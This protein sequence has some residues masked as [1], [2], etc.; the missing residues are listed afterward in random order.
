MKKAIFVVVWLMVSTL[1]FGQDGMSLDELFK[2]NYETPLTIDIDELNSDEEG[3]FAPNEK[4]GKEKK[5]NPK[6]FYGIKTKRGFAKQGIGNRMTVELFF[7]L[8]DKDYEG[9]T[10]YARD[11]YWYDFK[12]KKIVNSLKVKRANAGV[13]HGHYVKKLGDQ[14]IEEGYFYKGMKHSRWVRLNRHDIL[15]EKEYYWKGWPK[16]SRLAYYDFERENLREVIPVHFGER[17]GDYFAFHENGNLAVVGHYKFDQPVGIWREYY[18]NQRVKREVKYPLEA[19]D[20]NT[21]PAIIKEW[22]KEGKI[23]YDR[24]KFEA[25][26]N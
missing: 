1:G 5:K 23:I 2:V 8:K 11:F 14:V 3:E 9:P 26:A 15:Q 10:E 19:F 24:K 4:E 18:E 12:K 21:I 6:I 13:M 16:E 17:S 25:R 22:D 20:K 7:Y